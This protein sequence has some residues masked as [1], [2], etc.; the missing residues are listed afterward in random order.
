MR[1]RVRVSVRMKVRMRVRMR[2]RIRVT[3]RV[4]VRVRIKI[5]VSKRYPGYMEDVSCIQNVSRMYSRCVQDVSRIP[6]RW[7]PLVHLLRNGRR[8]P[9]FMSRVKVTREGDGEGED[10]MFW[11]PIRRQWV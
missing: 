10:Q 5:S 7:F 4:R 2:G 3:L 9:Y 1:V 8:Q 6:S 11:F